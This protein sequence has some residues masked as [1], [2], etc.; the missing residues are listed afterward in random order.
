MQMCIMK[1]KCMNMSVLTIL[2]LNETYQLNRCF[3]D[4]GLI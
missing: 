1:K 4:A 3:L 2:V